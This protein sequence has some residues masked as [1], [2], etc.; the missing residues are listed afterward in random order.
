MSTQKSYID[1]I[2]KGSIQDYKGGYELKRNCAEII[3]TLFRYKNQVHVYH[4][5]TKSY[6][7]HKGSDMLLDALTDFIDNFIEIY[8]GKY[9]RPDFKP[10]T[11]IILNNM[12][13]TQASLFLDEMINFYT[14]E[15]PKYLD[16]QKDTDLINIRDEILAATNKI[17]YLF[18][19][20]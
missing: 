10:D 8:M 3:Q 13:N 6:S 2:L 4:W 12:D 9:G 5:Q 19:L 18:T 20:E 7:R 16:L 1:L 14:N 15:L 11:S 17:K